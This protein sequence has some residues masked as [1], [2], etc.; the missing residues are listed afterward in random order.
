MPRLKFRAFTALVVLLMA[1][2]FEGASQSCTTQVLIPQGG[3][4]PDDRIPNRDV[5]T[6]LDLMV[7]RRWKQKVDDK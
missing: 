5:Y 3:E 6:L 7:D 4:R 1:G 2:R